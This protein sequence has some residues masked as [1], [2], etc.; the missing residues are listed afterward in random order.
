LLVAMLRGDFVAKKYQAIQILTKTVC[1][2]C[3]KR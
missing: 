3:R 2:M 1:T